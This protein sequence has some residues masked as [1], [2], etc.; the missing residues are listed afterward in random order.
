LGFC[1]ENKPSGNPAAEA[2]EAS[3]ENHEFLL[4]FKQMPFH[5]LS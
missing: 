5:Y 2:A 3:P 1:F 4:F